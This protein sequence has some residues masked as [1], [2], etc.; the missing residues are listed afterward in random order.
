MNFLCKL[1][2]FKYCIFYVGGKELHI[3]GQMNGWTVQLL[4]DPG[5]PFRS[6]HINPTVQLGGKI[7]HMKTIYYSFHMYYR[8][9][10]SISD[11]LLL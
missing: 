11:I 9:K 4:D 1:G 2:N 7:C 10:K 3:D 6:G 5:R 8:I